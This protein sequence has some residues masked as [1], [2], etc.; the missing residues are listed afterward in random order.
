M[1]VKNVI[2]DWS[3]VL[4]NDFMNVYNAVMGLFNDV[5]IKKLSV[6]EFREQLCLPYTK[7]YR[8]YNPNVPLEVIMES[9]KRNFE[10]Q[11]PPQLY[12]ETSDVL[13]TLHDN[14]LE[15]IILSS[16][17]NEFIKRDLQ[18]HGIDNLFKGIEGGI[19]DKVESIRNIM[20][21]HGFDP[22]ETALVGD[23]EHDIKAGKE[24]QLITVAS[25]YGY[26]DEKHL[27]RA[28]PDFFIRSIKDILDILIYMR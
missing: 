16:H 14:G 18:R 25:L 12:P 20:E 27:E 13:K 17:D 26:K 6:K 2:F 15:M 1:N 4:S 24:A 21:K 9:F 11:P 5:G 10:K 19:I 23:M 7:F 22:H 3:G 28:Q 8:K